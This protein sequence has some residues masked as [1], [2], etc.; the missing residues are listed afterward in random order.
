[1]PRVTI[2][3]PKSL[4]YDANQLA[5]CIG[6]GP[7][8]DQTYGDPVWKD[9]AGNTYAVASAVV[10]DNFASVAMSDLHQPEWGCDISA[11]KNAQLKVVTGVSASPDHIAAV[12]DDSPQ[13]AIQ[14]LGVSQ[15]N[16]EGD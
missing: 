15:S 5:R 14:T 4:I 16:T 1:M 10:G 12:F 6:L 9:A 11:A 13:S 2:A 3:C 7:D 8:D